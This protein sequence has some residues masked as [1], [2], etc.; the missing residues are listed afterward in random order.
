MKF[1]GEQTTLLECKSGNYC[2]PICR[3]RQCLSDSSVQVVVNITEETL[4][5]TDKKEMEKKA[6]KLHKQFAHAPAKILQSMLRSS[7]FKKSDFME[8]LENVCSN[9]EVCAKYAKPGNKPRSG[10]WKGRMRN[11]SEETEPDYSASVVFEKGEK[12]RYKKVITSIL[13]KSN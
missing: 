9:C 12:V 10:L 2:V 3:R 8:A 4:H 13:K 11:N 7:G 6:L 1:N 5:G